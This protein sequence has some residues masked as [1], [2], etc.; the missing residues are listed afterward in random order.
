MIIKAIIILFIL[1]VLWRTW[2]RFKVNDI[3]NRELI[4]WLFFWFLVIIAT[5]I[6]QKTDIIAQWL[7]VGRG[8]DLL[9]YISIIVLFFIAFRIIVK[10]EKIDRDIT[11]LVRKKALEKE[12]QSSSQG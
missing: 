3:T 1:F 6:P 5:L 4:I 11:K 10:L 2:L 9:V 7:G 8:A 12:D